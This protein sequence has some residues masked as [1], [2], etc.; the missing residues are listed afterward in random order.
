MIKNQGDLI[1]RADEEASGLPAWAVA[2]ADEVRGV[3]SH[4]IQMSDFIHC[5]HRDLQLCSSMILFPSHMS[6]QLE[7]W[8]RNLYLLSRITSRLERYA[9]LALKASYW[10]FNPLSQYA[11]YRLYG[12][13][14]MISGQTYHRHIL[15]N[16]LY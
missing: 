13:C 7:H 8:E 14:I 1:K 4:V 9:S 11:M 5:S 12:E 2:E 16:L 15:W 10:A 6:Y 3:H